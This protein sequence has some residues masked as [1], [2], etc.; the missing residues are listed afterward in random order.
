MAVPMRDLPCYGEAWF[1]KLFDRLIIES[2]S[3]ND[4]TVFIKLFIGDP[5]IN[6]YLYLITA[7][8]PVIVREKDEFC[9]KRMIDESALASGIYQSLSKC[10]ALRE[11]Y[12]SI[13]G[14]RT[15]DELADEE[16]GLEVGSRKDI[17]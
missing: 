7:E 1:D 12:Q 3:A 6:Q 11:K 13:S 8:P 9:S 5:P 14:Q 10:L 15:R 2:V 16:C 4:M 17:V